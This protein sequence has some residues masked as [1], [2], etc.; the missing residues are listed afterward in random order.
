MAEFF[1][2]IAIMSFLGSFVQI[3]GARL[4]TRSCRYIKLSYAFSLAVIGVYCIL[5]TLHTEQHSH[6][7]NIA[8]ALFLLE[9]N[10]IVGGIARL[11]SLRKTSRR[12][13]CLHSEH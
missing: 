9:F 12:T 1:I 6:L 11:I 2:V 10:V 8:G 5:D 3:W 7:I 4:E 13:E